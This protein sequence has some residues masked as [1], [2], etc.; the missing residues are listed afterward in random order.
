MGVIMNTISV[1]IVRFS[2]G[3]F[4]GRLVVRKSISIYFMNVRNKNMDI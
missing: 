4:R 1:R 3:S 2:G